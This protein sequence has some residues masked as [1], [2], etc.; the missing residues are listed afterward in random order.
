MEYLR[1]FGHAQGSASKPQRPRIMVSGH[2]KN[3]LQL[4]AHTIVKTTTRSER[5]AYES[6][7]DTDVECWFPRLRHAVNGT[8][9]VA[10][11][12]GSSMLFLQDLTAGMLA[13]CV[14][15]IKIGMPPG[16]TPLSP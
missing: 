6:L 4:G 8:S 11:E 15:D 12:E 9:A 13:P 5:A 2:V 10:A 14:M 1:L 7:V 3:F 16:L